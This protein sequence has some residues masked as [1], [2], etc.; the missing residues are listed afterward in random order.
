MR[1]LVT[2]AR[3]RLGPAATATAV[4]LWPFLYFLPRVWPFGG[5]YWT[6]DNDFEGL[7]YSYK[8]WLLDHLAL[9]R[10]PLWSPAEGAG[11]P[12]YSNPFAQAFY[13]LNAPLALLYAAAGG[14]SAADHQRFTVLGVS[15]FCVGLF[16]WLRSL[17][18]SVR[19]ALVAAATLGVSFKVAEI[20]RF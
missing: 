8:V 9:G 16:A 5:R 6:I 17:G 11:F 4:F 18:H 10:L 12:F 7:Y 13:P 19:A 20:L 14:Y 2:G 15:I 1:V 3:G